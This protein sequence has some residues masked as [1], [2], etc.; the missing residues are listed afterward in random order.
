MSIT[1]SQTEKIGSIFNG[2]RFLIPS[3][4]RKYSW[5]DD[6]RRALWQDI[7]ESIASDMDH[8]L[9]TVSFKEN[10]AEG[11]SADTQYEIID[12]Q[13]RVTTLFILLSVLID[14]LPDTAIRAKQQ[15]T[16]IGTREELK[17]Q[18]SGTDGKFLAQL[19]FDFNDVTASALRKRSWR[20]MA[21]AKRQFTALSSRFSTSDIEK[22]IM[23]V[24]DRI[25][26]LVFNVESQAQAVRMFSII[27][28]RGLPLR[29]LDKT[30]SVL[31]LYST[32]YLDATLNAEINSAFEKIFDSYDDLLSIRDELGIL[33]RFEENTVFT[34]HYYSAAQLFP[35]SWNN[36]DGAETIFK[37]LKEKCEALKSNPDSLAHFVQQYLNDFTQFALNYTGLISAVDTI[38]GYRKPFQFLEFT[39]TLYPLLV[40]LFMQ[41]KLN[42]LLPLLETTEVRVY[43]I[44]NTNPVADM[45]RLA[46]DVAHLKLGP[47]AVAK[48]LVDFNEKFVS[49]HN[50]RN[51]LDADLYQ[52]GAT[53]YILCEHSGDE[54]LMDA[55]S[56]WQVEHIFG[57]EPNFDPASH[58]FAED[59]DY[60]K[61]RLGNLTLL[62]SHI[63]S[64]LGN[65]APAQKV[66]GYVRSSFRVTQALAGGIN[67]GNF[68]KTEV[69]ERRAQII[70]FCLTRFCLAG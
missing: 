9:G 24:R 34:H 14:K 56:D 49:D 17:L 35:E 13:Q 45:Y 55:Y 6:E 4:Q 25:N 41:H 50:F 59:Y 47:A 62:E 36:R 5:T 23:F 29:I 27:N 57:K 68:S 39:A 63:N 7:E 43:K 26:V 22:R 58:G 70:D 33:G 19:I 65:C 18:P 30:K 46:S 8:F 1:K 64:G 51:Y 42:E 61:N 44:K 67:V 31:M 10:P 40:R 21:E 48:R 66:D 2:N 69:D 11:L 60:E 37:K 15:A 16:F 28:D 53:K 12:G 32:L 52:N 54:P 3:Y 38:P 20:F